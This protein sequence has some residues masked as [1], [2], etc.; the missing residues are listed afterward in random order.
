MTTLGRYEDSHWF[1]RNPKKTVVLFLIFI[2]IVLLTAI[3]LA[4]RLSGEKAGISRPSKKLIRTIEDLEVIHPSPFYTDEEGVFKAN[5][6]YNWDSG[7][8][9]KGVILNNDGFRSIEFKTYITSK[10]KI[11]FLGDSFTWGASAEPITNCFVDLVA[12]HGYLVFNTGIPGTDPEQYAF[13]TKKYVSFLQPDFVVAMVYMGNDLTI[14][15]SPMIP[16]KNLYYITNDIWLY[17]FDENNNYL[18]LEESFYRYYY[19]DYSPNLFKNKMKYVFASTVL[20]KKL[21][22]F[23]KSLKDPQKKAIEKGMR[24]NVFE[25]LN[26]IRRYSSENNSKFM[27]VII[28]TRPKSEVSNI[29]KK[30]VFYALRELNP[31]MPDNLS[32]KDYSTPPDNHLNNS[33]HLKMAKFI[34]SKIGEKSN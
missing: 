33:G 2:I 11:L 22:Q 18:T 23:V 20:G 9:G 30:E 4:L 17:A 10:K 16:G 25:I 24:N 3:E 12:E 15:P 1:E 14:K 34:V 8:Y 19:L 31:L 7:K 5:K 32:I 26:Q 6:A 28:P 29:R 21:W 13:L 27:L